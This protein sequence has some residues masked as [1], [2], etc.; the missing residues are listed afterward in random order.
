MVERESPCPVRHDRESH[1]C[2][3][4]MDWPP[5]RHGQFDDDSHEEKAERRETGAEPED[6]KHRE[7]D[8]SAAGQERHRDRRGKRIGTARKMQLE[9]VGEEGHRGVVELQESVP[10]EDAGS[11][12]GHRERKSQNELDKRWLGDRPHQATGLVDENGR[13][14][15]PLPGG[16]LLLHRSHRR[17]PIST[18]VN[19]PASIMPAIAAPMSNDGEACRAAPAATPSVS[20]AISADRN[21][22]PPAGRRR[23]STSKRGRV[24]SPSSSWPALIF[25]NGSLL[26]LAAKI[27]TAAKRERMILAAGC[28]VKTRSSSRSA[29]TTA[30]ADGDSGSASAA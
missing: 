4:D 8:F 10:L 28:G 27:V 21:S 9:L 18:E 13:G 6:E 14:T 20:P 5:I 19:A 22:A 16:G 29:G 24:I 17:S 11:P 15:E 30:S 2:P 1:R 25:S 23:T 12:E 26:R 7:D 3:G